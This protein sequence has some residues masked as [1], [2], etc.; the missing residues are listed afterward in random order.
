MAQT[1]LRYCLLLLVL[2]TPVAK[3]D[4]GPIPVQ[5]VQTADGWQLLRAG[6]PYFVRGAGWGTPMDSI[7]GAGGNTIRTWGVD[8]TTL[9][10]LDAAH[11]RGLTVLLGLWMQ[12]PENGFDYTDLDA[13]A[14]QEASLLKQAIQFKDHPAL[15]AYYIADEPGGAHIAPEKLEKV[16]ALCGETFH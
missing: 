6:K 16:Y 7:T 9:G 14:A 12:H 11:A 4:D 8:S 3:A 2:W 5:V 10:L 15:L 1:R 13:V